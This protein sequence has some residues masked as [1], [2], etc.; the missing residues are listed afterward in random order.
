MLFPRGLLYK[1]PSLC[2]EE[3]AVVTPIPDGAA[4]RSPFVWRRAATA[5][6]WARP[7]LMVGH[8][9]ARYQRAQDIIQMH[10]T[11]QSTAEGASKARKSMSLAKKKAQTESP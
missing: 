4:R 3:W 9:G 2:K 8:V 7:S 5:E 6:G 11:A 1:P 10:Q